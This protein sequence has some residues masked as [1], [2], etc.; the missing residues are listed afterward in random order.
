MWVRRLE[1]APSSTG[2][3][4]VNARRRDVT[5]RKAAESQSSQS[6]QKLGFRLG[7]LLGEPDL[8]EHR[9]GG[10]AWMKLKRS[11]KAQSGT[12]IGIGNQP[13]FE[14]IASADTWQSSPFIDGKPP[15]SD[16]VVEQ[17]TARL[18][19]HHLK[20]ASIGRAQRQKVWHVHVFA[21][22]LADAALDAGQAFFIA[23][24]EQKPL[25]ESI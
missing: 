22:Q 13:R 23:Q 21:G 14:E 4:G 24:L 9:I 1:F 8:C 16:Q 3:G 10:F 20:Q 19:A 6:G 18:L 17:K 2:K 25:D 5:V 11:A 12:A 7:V 15:T